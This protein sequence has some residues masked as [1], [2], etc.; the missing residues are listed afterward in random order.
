MT[1]ADS[2]ASHLVEV[3]SRTS[4]EDTVHRL[5]QA[6]RHAGLM[7]IAR[8]D[9]AAGARASGLEMPPT[10]VLIFGHPKGRTPVMQAVPTAALDLPL[11]VL[12]R[13]VSSELTVAA[14]HPVVPMLAQLGVPDELARPL[15]RAQQV[16]RDALRP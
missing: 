15:E 16:I 8:L 12:V 10:L 5:E 6:I 1:T 7:V 11:R 2:N 9:H 14:F 4:F 13:E 3:L